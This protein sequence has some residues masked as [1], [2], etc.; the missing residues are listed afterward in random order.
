MQTE[1]LTPRI[2]RALQKLQDLEMDVPVLLFLVGQQPLAFFLGQFLYLLVPLGALCG[3]S[4]VTEWAALL[5]HPQ[6]ATLI[7]NYLSGASPGGDAR[8]TQMGAR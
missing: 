2:R 8:S 4:I 7:Q 3:A 6:G 1:L 5:S